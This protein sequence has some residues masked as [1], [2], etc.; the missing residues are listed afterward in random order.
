[1]GTVS[2]KY[3]ILVILCLITEALQSIFILAI[4]KCA[5]IF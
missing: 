3:I 1:M 4:A 2:L 5:N